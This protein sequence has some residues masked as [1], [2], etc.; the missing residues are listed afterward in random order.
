MKKVEFASPEWLALGREYLQAEAQKRADELMGMRYVLCDVFTG[1]PEHLADDRGRLIWHIIIDGSQTEWNS[2]EVEDSDFN[3]EMSYE[4][5]LVLAHL[6]SSEFMKLSAQAPADN[7]PI[8]PD[9]PPL[10]SSLVSA[11]HD[12]LVARTL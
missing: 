10:I 5:G 11:A 1:A 12:S 7:A 2:G 9:M 3:F 6:T 4:Q 8:L